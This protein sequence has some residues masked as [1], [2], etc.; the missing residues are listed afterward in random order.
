MIANSFLIFISRKS[1]LI[2]RAYNSTLF[3]DTDS[4]KNKNCRLYSKKKKFHMI[5]SFSIHEIKLFLKQLRLV[6]IEL[7][8]HRHTQPR[9]KIMI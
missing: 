5:S 8:V 9:A 1:R 3:R 4:S 6:K 2:Y 7:L